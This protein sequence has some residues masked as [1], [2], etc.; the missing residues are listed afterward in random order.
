[1]LYGANEGY[2]GGIKI[3]G[4]KVFVLYLTY[5]SYGVPNIL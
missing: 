1:M 2:I 3:D 4:L 5:K